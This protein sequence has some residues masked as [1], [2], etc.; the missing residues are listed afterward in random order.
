MK[1]Y[2]FSWIA[3]LGVEPLF[4]SVFFL[5]CPAAVF[6]LFLLI[7]VFFVLEPMVIFLNNNNN[8]Y[9]RVL[10]LCQ[11]QH[12]VKI[13]VI[14]LII[15]NTSL[16]ATSMTSED[17]VLSIGEQ[18]SFKIKDLAYFSVGNSEVINAKYI[19]E[20]SKLFIKAKHIGFSDV[21]ITEKGNRRKLNFHIF[22]RQ[23]AQKLMDLMELLKEK[24]INTKVHG[25]FMEVSGEIDEM[26]IYNLVHKFTEKDDYI[27]NSLVL[28]K[29]LKNE[30][31]GKIYKEIYPFTNSGFNCSASGIKINCYIKSSTEK[32]KTLFSSLKQKYFVDF[33]ELPS[34]ID[35]KNYNIKLKL[36]H[37]EG[38]DETSISMG[39]NEI[40]AKNEDIF[41]TDLRAL[42]K[43]NFIRA[44]NGKI[45][46]E[47]IA[48]P[49][50][51][52]RIGEETMIELGQE[53]AFESTNAQNVTS[54][55]WKFA[56]LKIQLKLLNDLGNLILNY[57][58]ELS[59]PL[60][61]GVSG[62]KES[63]SLNIKEN[64]SVL[65]FKLNIKTNDK[66]TSGIPLLSK[67]PIIGALFRSNSKQI[68]YKTLYAFLK[69]KEIE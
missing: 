33:F 43:D 36:V 35:L 15:S 45:N 19:K 25:K 57:T 50:T 5:V 13:F 56:G 28:N 60:E 42:I 48:E 1:N 67:I 44:K 30:I 58:T 27:I 69:L 66:N 23:K 3:N 10:Y 8:S 11:R 32:F 18:K 2:L 54:I 39:M 7:L 17:F 63:S 22:N 59:T 4:L 53:M 21:I 12:L 55:N 31:I 68:T 61:K 65:M 51:T 40:L 62:T 38:G 6:L 46:I 14:S 37:I 41:N 64:Q 34:D 47:T 26:P 16:A 49:E 20:S 24:G 29:K 9:L 52:T